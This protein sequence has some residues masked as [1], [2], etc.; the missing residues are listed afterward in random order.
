MATGLAVV[1]VV[2]LTGMVAM[3]GVAVVKVLRFIVRAQEG[4]VG[5][6]ADGHVMMF[7]CFPQHFKSFREVLEKLIC[8]IDEIV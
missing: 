2:A 6:V 4:L 3:R 1:G 8:K 5:V 7:F